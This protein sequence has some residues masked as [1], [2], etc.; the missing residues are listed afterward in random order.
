MRKFTVIL[1]WDEESQQF[2]VSVPAL[3][4]C[5]THGATRDEAFLRA[6][7]AIRGHVK[8]LKTIGEPFPTEDV[9]VA[10]VEVAIE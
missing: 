10:F 1:D 6:K 7:E 2:N 9:E 8:G 5:F 4:G 3:E